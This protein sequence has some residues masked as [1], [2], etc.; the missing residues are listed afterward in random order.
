MVY[1]TSSLFLKALTLA[2]I[3][4]VFVNWGS[5]HPAMLEELQRQRVQGEHRGDTSPRVITCPNEM[6][7][8]TA[9]HGYAQATGKPAAVI[10]H[11]DVGT[12]AL[13]GAIH[14]AD[15]GRVPVLI[16]AGASPFSSRNEIKGGRNEWIM[17]LQ[18]VPD[19]TAIVRQYMRYTAQINSGKNVAQVVKRALQIATTEPKGPVYLWARREVMEE[20]VPFTLYDSLSMKPPVPVSPTGLSPV[21]TMTITN[22]LLASLHPLII[23]SHTGRN[24]DA[25]SSLLTLSTVLAIPIFCTCPSAVN[26]PFSHPYLFG[27]TYISPGPSAES[28]KEHLRGA[29]VV[30]VI[31]SDVPWIP[32]SCAPKEDGSARVF[33]IDGGDPLKTTVAMGTWD[34]ALHRGVEMICRADSETAIGQVV[35]FVRESIRDG[36][37]QME[38]VTNEIRERV[39]ERAMRSM[40]VHERWVERLDGE[41]VAAKS[42]YVTVPQIMRALQE[43]TAPISAKSLIV[44]EAISNYGLVWEHARPELPGSFVTSGGSSLGYALGACVGAI[45][46]D[47][48]A[49]ASKYELVTAIVG[50]G[51]FMFGVPSSAFWIARR[52]ETPF[53]TIILNN[54]GWRS[55]KLS[56]LGVHPHGHGSGSLSGEQLSVGFSF[57]ATSNSTPTQ[58][59]RISP[60][61]GQIA[62]AATDGWAWGKKVS[63]S[64]GDAPDVNRLLDS[65]KDT[66]AEAV[67]V[68]IEEKRCAVVDC[69]LEAL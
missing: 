30:L 27:I 7:A 25:V 60:N 49:G 64:V 45:L 22:A 1:T 38:A 10:I 53:L 2:G 39:K 57:D 55:P 47:R 67:R 65:L 24:P 14:N 46:G 13:A 26:V 69:M 52:Y 12:Q 36:P 61:Y 54:G 31:D 16:Y 59:D 4:H 68:V 58:S 15:R 43:V 44:G 6:V 50:D 34:A 41:E 17:W 20:E 51:A 63:V 21:D 35:E 9:A 40:Q 37:T 18:D 5:D 33:I 29:D 56:M 66:L 32:S 62:V 8:L 28:F 48:V 23:T 3:T 42:R 19:Q 11:V